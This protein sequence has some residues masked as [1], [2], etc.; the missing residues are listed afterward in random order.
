[1]KSAV[2]S[3]QCSVCSVQC[4]VCGVQCAVCSVQ[5]AVCSVQCTVCSVQ[6]AVCSVKCAVCS[7]KC[8]V[9][10]VQCEV[11]LTDKGVYRTAPATPGLL[12][13]LLRRL[14]KQTLLNVTPLLCKIKPLE[15]HHFTL[16]YIFSK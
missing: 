1:M 3:V 9:F 15:I 12:T 6:C 8:K 4:A 7:V 13:S 5:C 14:Q 10:N 11:S 2:C 16:P